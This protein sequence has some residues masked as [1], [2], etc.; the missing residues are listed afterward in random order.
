MLYEYD[1][2]DTKCHSLFSFGER[3]GQPHPRGLPLRTFGARPFDS[4]IWECE[5]RNRYHSVSES[6]LDSQGL[7]DGAGEQQTSQPPPSPGISLD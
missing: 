2:L 6:I 7:Q 1:A 4:H 3:P 5:L